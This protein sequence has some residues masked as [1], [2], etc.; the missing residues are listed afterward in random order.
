[1]QL[2]ERDIVDVGAVVPMDAEGFFEGCGFGDDSEE[3]VT[4]I[5]VLSKLDH[6]RRFR[7]GAEPLS[8]KMTG[9]T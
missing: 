5:L 3:S 7:R 1:V 2:Y 4:M 6:N 9:G 8:R